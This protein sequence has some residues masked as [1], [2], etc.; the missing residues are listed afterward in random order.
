MVF[1]IL[2]KT[3]TGV[4]DTAAGL[5]KDTVHA[6]ANAGENL[7]KTAEDSAAELKPLATEAVTKVG[8]VINGT[9]SVVKETGSKVYDGVKSTM[10][11][12]TISTTSAA[13]SEPVAVPNKTEQKAIVVNQ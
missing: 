3:L 6:V 5:V 11:Q 10:P 1:K 8:N 9:V 13:K 7:Q 12:M 4:I 2:E